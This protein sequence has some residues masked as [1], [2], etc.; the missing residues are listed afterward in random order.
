MIV[1]HSGAMGDIIYHLPVIDA[2]GGAEFFFLPA[3]RDGYRT[4]EDMQY[5]AL[6]PLLEVQPY[7]TA[8]GWSAVPVGL[9][10]DAW[11]R[12]LDFSKNLTTQATQWLGMTPISDSCAPWLHGVEPKVVAAVT[13]S[14][15]QRNH[16]PNFPWRQVVE[17]YGAKAVFLGTVS[18]HNEFVD[19]YGFVQFY[20]TTDFLEL[21]AVIKGGKFHIGNPS[22]PVAVAEGLKHPCIVASFPEINA[23]VFYHR[24]GHQHC[25]DKVDFWEA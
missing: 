9:C 14:R 15:S 25:W 17:K 10:F 4:P 23:C 24:P 18:E 8:V 20:P 11:R 1:S 3:N 22:G 16:H 2:L 19:R 5:R 12:C 13:L 7:L 21:A 6:K